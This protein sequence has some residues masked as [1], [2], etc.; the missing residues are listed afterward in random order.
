MEQRWKA[1][2]E[3]QKVEICRKEEICFE[4]TGVPT[5]EHPCKCLNRQKRLWVFSLSHEGC[6]LC[7]CLC[8]QPLLSSQ[9]QRLHCP[10]S[11]SMRT[12]IDAFVSHKPQRPPTG[13]AFP[14]LPNVVMRSSFPG[15]I[16][17]CPGT[18]FPAGRRRQTGTLS[19]VKLFTSPPQQSLGA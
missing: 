6:R 12:Q 11:V 7:V 1:A 3:G 2:K 16:S 18:R 17:A 14:K 9:G 5:T 19:P 13:K 8:Q 4:H 15:W 10:H